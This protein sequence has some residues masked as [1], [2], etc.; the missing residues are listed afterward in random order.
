MT[1]PVGSDQENSYEQCA[2]LILALSCTEQ[3]L[4]VAGGQRSLLSVWS[5]QVLTFLVHLI[6]VCGD[7][8]KEVFSVL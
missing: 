6:Q 4:R 1:S 3:E 2:F 7:G 8:S 5:C